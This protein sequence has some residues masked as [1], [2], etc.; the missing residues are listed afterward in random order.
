ME[1]FMRQSLKDYSKHS[2]DA[3]TF[4]ILKPGIAAIAFSLSA[5]F[6]KKKITQGLYHVIFETAPQGCIYFKV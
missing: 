4:F 1:S 3:V 6:L 2:Q 5:C